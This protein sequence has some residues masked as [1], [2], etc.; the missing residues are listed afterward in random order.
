L[1]V[2]SV[3]LLVLAYVCACSW[4]NSCSGVM[5]RLRAIGNSSPSGR[6]DTWWVEYGNDKIWLSVIALHI[7]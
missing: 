5:S 3:L 6:M 7:K 4:R 1:S 2:V